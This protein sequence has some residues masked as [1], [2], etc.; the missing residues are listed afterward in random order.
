MKFEIVKEMMVQRNFK[1]YKIKEDNYIIGVTMN[2][3]GN[4]EYI[5]IK[6]Y[7]GKFE[8]KVV[9][10]FL[11]TKFNIHN[12]G[13][14]TKIS[15]KNVVQLIIICK[16]FQNSHVKEFKELSPHIQLI[17][18]DFFNINITKKAPSHL[19][20]DGSII[21]NKKELPILKISDPNCIF[22]NFVKGDLIKIIRSDGEV[23]YRLVR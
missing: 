11:S 4:N 18:S 22:Y 14:T 19:K 8:I 23:C 10:E 15:N 5:Y 1:E 12:E 17:R 20:V 2:T 6:I 13:V 3:L 21:K 7:P 16:S 9:R